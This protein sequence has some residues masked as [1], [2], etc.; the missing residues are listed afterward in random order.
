[1][2]EKI[3]KTGPVDP[4]KPM[5]LDDGRPVK[6][7]RVERDGY[8]E[9]KFTGPYRRDGTPAAHLSWLYDPDTGIWAGGSAEEMFVLRNVV[10]ATGGEN[11]LPEDA[12]QR[13]SYPMA[14]G[15]LDYF[16]NALAEVSR[17]S[18]VG[19]QQHN[20]GEPMHWARGKSTDHGNKIMRHLIDAGRKDDKG[21][22][23]SARLAWRALAMLQEELEREEG[24]PMSRGSTP[25]SE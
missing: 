2:T 1:M 18:Y 14:D 23:H 10:T 7:R 5:E 6:L 19:N 15:L 16:P 22:R 8:I 21:I 9:V 17:V 20:P 13:N 3:F 12:T 25:P 24:V 4:Q 11:S